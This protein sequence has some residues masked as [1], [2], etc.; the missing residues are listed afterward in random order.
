MGKKKVLKIMGQEKINLIEE[1]RD[2]TSKIVKDSISIFM[3]LNFVS[4]LHLYLFESCN[5]Y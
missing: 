2:N 4:Y 5:L 1:S 3:N